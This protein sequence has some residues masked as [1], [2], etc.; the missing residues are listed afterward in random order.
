MLNETIYNTNISQIQYTNDIE[1]RECL[2]LVFNMSSVENNDCDIDSVTKDENNYDCESSTKA[3]DFIYNITKDHKSFQKLYDIAASKMFSV[4]R[5]IG[6]AVLFSYDYMSL[7][8]NCLLSYIQSPER[9][10]E[11]DTSFCALHL[12]IR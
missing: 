5:E 10:N 9:F 2:R 6:L 1:Y 12:K 3:M 8:H 11:N 7:F 4:D